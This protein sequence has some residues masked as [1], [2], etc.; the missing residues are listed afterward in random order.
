LG[1]TISA[2]EADA[3]EVAYKCSCLLHLLLLG[4]LLRHAGAAVS[5]AGQGRPTA[6]LSPLQLVFASMGI[7][8]AYPL[9]KCTNASIVDRS[10]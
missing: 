2:V 5:A 7:Q 10:Q 1:T 6:C 9:I 3:F 8:I 4:L